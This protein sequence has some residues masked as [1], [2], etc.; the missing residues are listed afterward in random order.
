MPGRTRPALLMVWN[1]E[2][3]GSGRTKQAIRL[4]LC[5]RKNREREGE[6]A[7]EGRRGA[8]RG[9]RGGVQGEAAGL[10]RGRGERGGSA[11]HLA[12]RAYPFVPQEDAQAKQELQ[13]S[14]N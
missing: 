9:R 12:A 14:Q 2:V 8:E 6:R 13:T 11:G 4:G 10:R 7:V 3:R 5:A 1:R